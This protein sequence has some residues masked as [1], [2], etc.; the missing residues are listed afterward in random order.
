M[1][2]GS[3]GSSKVWEQRNVEGV[4]R[5]GRS[6]KGLVRSGSR[7]IFKRV[8]RSGSR[9][10]VEGVVRSRK[11]V[12]GVVVWERFRFPDITTISRLPDLTTP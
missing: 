3:Q 9:E 4:V 2:S 7:E 1:R 10:I 6:R 8:V 11:I 5:S 12:D